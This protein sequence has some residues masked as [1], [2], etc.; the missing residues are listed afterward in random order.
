MGTAQRDSA[1]CGVIG[2]CESNHTLGDGRQDCGPHFM[3][4]EPSG[5][6]GMV[7]GARAQ[8]E[9]QTRRQRS[10]DLLH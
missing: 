5:V 2:S 10:W 7:Q 4:E 6:K 3:D 9:R 1:S 8:R